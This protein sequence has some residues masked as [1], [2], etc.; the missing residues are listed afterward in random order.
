MYE[1]LGSSCE[2]PFMKVVLFNGSPRKEGNTFQLLTEVSR[3]LEEEGIETEIV[4]VGGKIFHG[5]TA[6][7]KCFENKNRRCVIDS[8]GINECISK[9]DAADGIIIGSPT[10]FADVTTEIKALIDRAG[11]VAMANDGML[12]RKVGAAVVAVRR[13]GAIHAFDSINHFFGIG[14]MFTVGSSN[15]NVGIGFQPGDVGDD[16]TG[17]ETMQNLG[18]NMAWILKKIHHE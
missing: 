3:S 4:Q 7:M 16:A 9:M 8:D 17:M 5:C 18:K 2:D 13:S 6:C 10:Y 15:W 12:A 14:S 1:H 11:L